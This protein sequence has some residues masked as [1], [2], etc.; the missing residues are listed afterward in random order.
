MQ[1]IYWRKVCQAARKKTNI[2]LPSRKW[3]K[4]WHT[5]RSEKIEI[6]KDIEIEHSEHK[7]N[8]PAQVPTFTCLNLQDVFNFVFFSFRFSLR[9]SD[10][11][12]TLEIK[13]LPYFIY[14]TSFGFDLDMALMISSM[15]LHYVWSFVST[16]VCLKHI[17]E[18][19]D[20]G[21]RP[22][23]FWLF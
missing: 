20:V 22:R 11:R 14:L 5:L 23:S 3:K 13:F 16:F 7:R 8:Q 12:L 19:R 9:L 1:E 2:K 10:G 17:G 6:E 15:L 21:R 4:L 18:C